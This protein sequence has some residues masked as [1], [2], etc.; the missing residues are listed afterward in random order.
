MKQAKQETFFF[1][2]LLP[3]NIKPVPLHLHDDNYFLLQIRYS[4]LSFFFVVVVVVMF[5]QR[6]IKIQKKDEY[7]YSF[8]PHTTRRRDDNDDKYTIT[9]QTILSELLHLVHKFSF[10]LLFVCLYSYLAYLLVV[11]YVHFFFFFST[12]T[13]SKFVA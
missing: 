2:P 3:I 13:S 8:L 5:L 1:F 12:S 11:L 7:K 4:F 10:S 9:W 6:R